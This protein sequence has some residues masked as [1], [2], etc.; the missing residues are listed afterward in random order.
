[1]LKRTVHHNNNFSVDSSDKLLNVGYDEESKN[2]YPK[3]DYYDTCLEN[4]FLEIPSDLPENDIIIPKVCN[5]IDNSIHD[6]YLNDLDNA[7]SNNKVHSIYLDTL[8]SPTAGDFSTSITQSYSKGISS[9]NKKELDKKFKQHSHTKKEKYWDFK[10][11]LYLH[12]FFKEYNGPLN[13][14]DFQ[15]ELDLPSL[16]YE[17][18]MEDTTN[19]RRMYLS[20]LLAIILCTKLNFT[21][22]Y[23]VFL[24]LAL[25][26]IFSSYHILLDLLKGVDTLLFGYP[27]TDT[28][29][30]Y[31]CKTV[32]KKMRNYKK[33]IKSKIN[34]PIKDLK[35]HIKGIKI[36]IKNFMPMFL[37]V[38]ILG[39]KQQIEIDSGASI[40]CI[41]KSLLSTICP[42]Y[43]TILKPYN[44]RTLYDVQNNVISVEQDRLIP[45]EI[46]GYGYL[47]HRF[48]ILDEPNVFL[49]GRDLMNKTKMSILYKSDHF[50]EIC[51]GHHKKVQIFTKIDNN[52][53]AYNIKNDYRSI[54]KGLGPVNPLKFQPKNIYRISKIINKSI[55]KPSQLILKQLRNLKKLER[56]SKIKIIF[57]KSKTASSFTQFLKLCS[58][59]ALD[60]SFSQFLRSLEG[61]ITNNSQVNYEY[62]LILPKFEGI[63]FI[64]EDFA[65]YIHSKLVK[66]NYEAP[67]LIF[68]NSMYEKMVNYHKYYKFLKHQSFDELVYLTYQLNLIKRD[69]KKSY[70]SLFKPVLEN[71]NYLRNNINQV[72]VENIDDN[73]NIENEHILID[74]EYK[75]KIN[76]EYGLDLEHL[77]SP[78]VKPLEEI[79]DE[80]MIGDN[81]YKEELAQY[82]YDLSCSAAHE[83]DVGKLN[84]SIPPMKLELKPG[85]S[86]PRNTR[87]YKLNN[88]DTEHLQNF[89][90]YL[91]HHKL[92]RPSKLGFGSPCFLIGRKEADRLPR[93]IFDVRAVNSVLRNDSAAT[94]PEPLSLLKNMIGDVKYLTIIDLKNCFYSLSVDEETLEQ[95]FNNICTPWGTVYTIVRAVT[96]MSFVPAYLSNILNHYLHV[97]ENG[98]YSML[99]WIISFFD[100]LIIHST[101]LDSK[102]DHINKV[103]LVLK[104]LKRI[105]FKVGLKKCHFLIDIDKEDVEILGY[106]LYQGKIRIPPKKLEALKRVKEPKT[107]KEL[108]SLTGSL[109][110]YRSLL[111][112]EALNS[113]NQLYKLTSDFKLSPSLSY[114]FRRIMNLLN[115][116]SHYIAG[117]YRQSISLVIPDASQ[118]GL[119]AALISYDVS[120]L[121][122]DIEINTFDIEKEAPNAFDYFKQ[123]NIHVEG[124]SVHKNPIECIFEGLKQLEYFFQSTNYVEFFILLLTKGGLAVDYFHFLPIEEKGTFDSFINNMVTEKCWER[125]D[126]FNCPFIYSFIF[127]VTS[128]LI[129]RRITVLVDHQGNQDSI[130][131]LSHSFGSASETLYFY[132]NSKTSLYYS[133]CLKNDNDVLEKTMVH[134]S[135]HM[136]SDVEVKQAFYKTLKSGKYSDILKKVRITSYYSKVIDKDFMKR[137][138]ICYLESYSVFEALSHFEKDLTSPFVYILCDSEVAIACLRNNKISSRVN[139]L[140][141]LS[142][143]IH[144]YFGDRNLHFVAIKSTHNISDFISRLLPTLRSRLNFKDPEPNYSCDSFD[145]L[146]DKVDNISTIKKISQKINKNVILC[147]NNIYN[148]FGHSI[149]IQENKI[150]DSNIL[151]SKTLG[152]HNVCVKGCFLHMGKNLNISNAESHEIMLRNNTN[153]FKI[154]QNGILLHTIYPENGLDI[155]HNIL[156]MSTIYKNDHNKNYMKMEINGG[157]KKVETPALSTRPFTAGFRA[158]EF[159]KFM[160]KSNFIYFQL[161]EEKCDNMNPSTLKYYKNKILLPEKLYFLFTIIYHNLLSHIGIDSLYNYIIKFFHVEKKMI[162]KKHITN[163]CKNCLPCLL[164]KPVVH[165]FKQASFDTRR[166]TKPNELLL[167]DL[168]ELPTTIMGGYHGVSAIAVMIDAYSKYVQAYVMHSK[169]QECMIQTLTNYFQSCGYYSQIY[170]DNAPCFTGVKIKKF[171]K[172]NNVQI[173]PASPLS[174]KSHGLI[175]RR[176]RFLQ[177]MIRY[178]NVGKADLNLCNTLIAYGWA[179]NLIPFKGSLLC[180]YNLQFSSVRNFKT[181]NDVDNNS[182]FNTGNILPKDATIEELMHFNSTLVRLIREF[183]EMYLKDRLKEWRKKNKNKRFHTYQLGDI[184]FVRDY[185]R[186]KQRPLFYLTLHRVVKVNRY[187]LLIENLLS[188]SVIIRNPTQIKKLDVNNLIKTDLPSELLKDLKILTEDTCND[189]LQ[190]P[191]LN[192]ETRKSIRIP[193]NK[194]KSKNIEKSKPNSKSN[195]NDTY[196]DDDIQ[197]ESP[198][199]DLFDSLSLLSTIY[200]EEEE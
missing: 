110:Y 7:Y 162:L 45:L 176:I 161:Q 164:G 199:I 66:D 123:K 133:L 105:G 190:F 68:L 5:P 48:A 119:G 115:R 102:E 160:T 131:T 112:L 122:K 104:R 49:L 2:R 128:R 154:S 136:K 165:N 86:L 39:V 173:I 132:Y 22:F 98:F 191:L 26:A 18:G 78:M 40:S 198:Q 17:D 125:E 185:D 189:L 8:Y 61:C 175:E 99:T 142:Q 82:I 97:D 106:S 167:V 181:S 84:S 158:T 111:D 171:L 195:D 89:F 147:R 100:D 90:S 13:N 120:D 71:I 28:P 179:L 148:K 101:H 69:D 1:M 130:Q 54:E 96:G 151:C 58:N 74:E 72:S 14:Y 42:N 88:T 114:H 43:E 109:N 107:L 108:Q 150:I 183:R 6:I 25:S 172:D 44:P 129:N 141:T 184:V 192:L 62:D 169:T 134:F 29:K 178:N 85:K 3:Q 91:C 159:D 41:S 27:Y 33:R 31:F 70:A 180:P 95:G 11:D 15:F 19:Y 126:L 196:D 50:Y 118:A 34:M 140:N 9:Y 93:I 23:L 30:M 92:A 113:L 135:D 156:D 32:K 65:N 166:L 67:N 187:S 144:H 149:M 46:K 194:L 124:M 163:L 157:I 38:I 83:L 57:E 21:T 16:F 10:Y 51:F 77:L 36:K 182:L 53:K 139:K 146:T 170:T 35:K 12:S 145:I 174:S 63:K 121:V 186:L 117:S 153:A 94:L 143:K 55:Y 155:S 103:K 20:K 197:E 75:G 200:E 59:I 79:M 137:N 47:K 4:L 37:P 152:H 24:L 188:R 60:L 76:G 138:P 87:Y 127:L 64:S 193:R 81:R 56:T 73:D 168:L 52:L 116:R 177:E 80:I